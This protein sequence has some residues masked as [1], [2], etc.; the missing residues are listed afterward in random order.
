MA[1]ALCVLAVSSQPSA[2]S[3]PPGLTRGVIHRPLLYP[4]CI[5]RSTVDN[6]GAAAGVRPGARRR[7]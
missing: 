7:S 6:S 1:H 2:V 3:A 5:F 4:T